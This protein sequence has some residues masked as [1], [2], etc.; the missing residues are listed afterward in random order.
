M[1]GAVR[2]LD[3]REEAGAAAT[4]LSI[5]R[6]AHSPSMRQSAIETWRGRMINEHRSGAV[7]DALARQIDE[8]GFPKETVDACA[9]FGDEERRH[10][11]LCGAVVTA[12][13]GQALADVETPRSLP[14]H[15]DVSRLEAVLRNLL[16]VSCLSE[17]V[18]VA[19]IGAERL[20]MEDGPLRE[21]LTR[22][23]ADEIGHAR[24]GWQIV[25][26]IVPTLDAKTRARL[27]AYLKVAFEHL[28]SHELSHLPEHFEPPPG[29]EA[30][31]L[32]SGREGRDIFFDTV[33]NVIAPRLDSLGLAATTAWNERASKTNARGA[34]VVRPGEP[35]RVEG[36]SRVA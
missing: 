25:S 26:S 36:Q 17:T 34:T 8:A 3:L 19:L 9:A 18:A 15:G 30:L 23:W 5:D 31:G 4:C 10:G 14:L 7:F 35:H 32:C 16:S 33:A 12:L 2:V 11:V 22:I 29:G 24:F 1:D 21:L 20:A 27:T 28:E 13:G 6:A